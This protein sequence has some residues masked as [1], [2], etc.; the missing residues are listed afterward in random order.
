M[1]P[2]TRL[3][4]TRMSLCLKVWL[5]CKDDCKR[6]REWNMTAPVSSCPSKARWHVELV[7]EAGAVRVLTWLL[8]GLVKAAVP[9]RLKNPE[10]Q[11]AAQPG[12]PDDD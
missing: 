1:L 4:H 7:R 9:A 6:E 2:D 3:Q 11:E 8:L 5:Q 12:S 10:Q